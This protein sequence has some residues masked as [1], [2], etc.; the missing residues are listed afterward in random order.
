[1]ETEL[2]IWS[3]HNLRGTVSVRRMGVFFGRLFISCYQNKQG[4]FIL[5]LCI[6]PNNC[7]YYHLLGHMI[8]KRP[9]NFID[10]YS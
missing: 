9:Y 1:M 6:T 8:N 4:Y 5:R 10:L 7:Y 2:W 3:R